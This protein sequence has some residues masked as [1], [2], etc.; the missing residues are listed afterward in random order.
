MS[1]KL[2]QYKFKLVLKLKDVNCN[3]HG[4]HKG[5]N[6]RIYTR[7]NEKGIKLFHYKKYQLNTKED[8]DAVYEWGG[9][10]KSHR[11]HWKMTE[12]SNFISITLNI[13]EL[14]SPFKKQRLAEW[15]FK[16]NDGSTV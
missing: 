10:Y 3:T 15:I 7:G 4:N 6:C 1:L 8:S 14:N 11:K 12:V 5:N 9:D 2:Q 13:N 16:K